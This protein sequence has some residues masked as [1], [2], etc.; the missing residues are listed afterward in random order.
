MKNIIAPIDKASLKKELSP[1]K[2]LRY[3]NYGH[4]EVYVITAHDSPQTMLEL[5]RLREYT[6]REAGGGTGKEVDIDE[7]DTMPN[8]YKQLL[9]WDPKNEDIIGG[10]RFI[11]GSK[12]KFTSEKK[13]VLSTTEIF[14]F[15]DEFLQ[16]ILPNII[17]LGRSFIQPLYQSSRNGIFSLDNLWDGL[18][19]L[20]YT[21]KEMQAFFG[22]VTMYPA[23]NIQARDTLLY[24]VQKYHSDYKNLAHPIHP[25]QL[26]SNIADLENLYKGLSLEAAY[27][28]MTKRIRELGENV[29]PLFNSYL[30]LSPTMISFGTSINPFFGD[31]EETGILIRIDE[32]YSTKKERH[33][34]TTPQ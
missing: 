29:P 30:K 25:L 17:E 33:I 10:Y 15:S 28:V 26:E 12:V 13:P 32:I 27:K 16:D 34:P 20:V 2:F 7:F 31:V 18:G 22:K 9:V 8:P 6:F 3:T 21:H 4:R 23:Y 24:Y 5:G 1:D 19:G 11:E 14:D